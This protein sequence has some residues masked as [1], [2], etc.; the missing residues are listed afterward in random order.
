MSLQKI[1]LMRR[2]NIGDLVCTTPLLR[3]LRARFPGARIAAYVNS[4]NL[5]VLQGNPDVSAV[6]AYTKAKHRPSGSSALPLYWRRVRQLFALRGERFDD[7][8]IAE[9]GYAARLV[10][11]ARWLAPQRI[12]GFA[13]DDG[14]ARGLDVA[15]PR[16]SERA[17]HESEDVFRLL[18]PYGIVGI[19]PALRVVARPSGA[20]H[21]T[22][23]PQGTIIGL[24]ISAR[25]LSQRWPA[26]NFI[27]LASHLCR[28]AGVSIKLFW[29]PGGAA[30]ALHPGDDDKAGVILAGLRNVAVEGVPTADL[31]TLVDGLGEC[32][33]VICSDGGAMHIAA[34]LGKPLVCLFG[35]SDSKRWYPW[36]VAY[37]LLQKAS[38]EVGDISVEEV[39][40]AF[41]LLLQRVTIASSRLQN[42]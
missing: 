34:G 35:K 33:Y 16:H 28:D 25:K 20:K 39:C 24:H 17:L 6:Y 29:S 10:C 40:S 12:I 23:A 42:G 18:Q 26:E 37:E 32:D 13:R 14:Y 7:V 36:G 19:P 31:R 22:P 5:P 21:N 2:D 4:Y 41:Q 38:G 30:N 15:L 27:K 8:I 1:L 3:A 9:P 11:L